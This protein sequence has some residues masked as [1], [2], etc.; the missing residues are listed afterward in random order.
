MQLQYTTLAFV[1]AI[2][3]SSVCSPS[4]GSSWVYTF[5]IATG[6]SLKSAAGGVTGTKLGTHLG[7]GVTWIKLT[8]GTSRLIIP[9]SDAKIDVVQPPTDGTDVK[10]PAAGTPGNATRTSWRELLD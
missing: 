2:P 3:G 8:N 9:G 1:S 4:G 7:V 5:D 6:G 10:T